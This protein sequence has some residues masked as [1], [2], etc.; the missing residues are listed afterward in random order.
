V[1]HKWSKHLLQKP[2]VEHNTHVPDKIALSTMLA[3]GV[4][5]A[6]FS[7]GAM[8]PWWDTT[9]PTWGLAV[10]G[11]ITA[12]FAGYTLRVISRQTNIAQDAARAAKDSA[13]AALLQVQAVINSERPWVV[14]D[15]KEETPAEL[16]V[17]HMIN[18]GRTPAEI[19]SVNPQFTIQA[20][21]DV[22]P[23]GTL[24]TLTYPPRL[25]ASGE[26][27][28]A[29]R[30]LSFLAVVPEGDPLRELIRTN[31]QRLILWGIVKYLA[32]IAADGIIHE[33]HY[34]FWL[35]PATGFLVRGGPEGA[36]THT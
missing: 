11:F 36:N 13:N 28:N 30:D 32:P 19:I 27:W 34:C 33:T 35:N 4:L 12:I 31:S 3:H 1:D 10:I 2:K 7:N 24:H 8:P 29:F 20:A 15:V 22:L 5:A 6:T 23:K 21:L 17:F 26:S 25:L 16:F 14:V 9:W 18:I